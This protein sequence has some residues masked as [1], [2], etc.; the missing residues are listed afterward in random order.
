MRAAMQAA[1]K[2]SQHKLLGPLCHPA[3]AVCLVLALATGVS[4]A[5]GEHAPGLPLS[6]LAVVV[7]FALAALKGWLVVDVF[8]GLRGAPRL[9]RWLVRGW[10]LV[11]C[12]L[13]LGVAL[14]RH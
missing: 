5:L 7:I 6:R 3:N 10:V 1:M 2:T 14:F 11:V 8:M 9:W 4:Y 12:S 13:L